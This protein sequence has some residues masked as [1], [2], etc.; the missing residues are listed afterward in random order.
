MKNFTGSILKRVGSVLLAVIVLL[1]GTVLAFGAPTIPEP[2]EVF[3]VGDFAGVLTQGTVDHIVEKNG[4]LYERSGAQIVVVTV[5]FLGGA[6]IEDYARLLF[7]RWEIGDGERNNGVLLLLA[8]GEENYWCMQGKG[9]EQKLSSGRI[10]DLLYDYL[11]DDFAVG[12]Y[13]EGVVK[14][15]DA[16]Y[17]EV[18]KLYP[19]GGGAMASVEESYDAYQAKRQS[20]ISVVIGVMVLVGVI[21]LLTF[22]AVFSRRGTPYYGG[23]YPRPPRYR[24]P[25]IM[26][27]P[28]PH[29]PP[30]PSSGGGF[31]GGWS[32]GSG[33]GSSSSSRSSSSRGSS[34]GGSRS[35]GGR[36]SGG[37]SSGG[38]GSS[39]GG[40]A[41]R[42]GR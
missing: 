4:E 32:G 22:V 26:P 5:E 7:N 11:E 40:G 34:F 31:F 15:F 25:P 21:V 8:T 17:K 38:G 27:P 3:Y 13:D 42:R 36:S 30:P 10:D 12:D 16:L 33:S 39:R 19:T 28:P 20:L 6:D 29:S 9:L 37:R 18:S 1:G 41:G 35:S 2:T 14:V 23:M 24:R